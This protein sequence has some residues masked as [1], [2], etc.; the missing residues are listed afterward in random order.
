MISNE[1]LK[2]TLY[3]FSV[4]KSNK[5]LNEN[6]KNHESLK[7]L[8]DDNGAI[9]YKEVIGCYMGQFEQS[10]LIQDNLEFALVMAKLYEQECI[11]ELS[12][13]TRDAR[14][15]YTLTQSPISV[16]VF[17]AVNKETALKED[18]YTYDPMT[19]VY[20]ITIKKGQ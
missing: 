3:I 1:N 18:N 12:A 16:G 6:Q 20:Y 5:S 10:F 11:L 14:L 15:I 17:T 7:A 19:G 9:A 2:H 4:Y 8:I 13:F